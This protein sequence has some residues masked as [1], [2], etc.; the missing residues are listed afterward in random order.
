M[1]GQGVVG[2][3]ERRCGPGESLVLGETEDTCPTPPLHR[4]LQTGQTRVGGAQDAKHTAKLFDVILPWEKGDPF[5]S[6][7]RMHPTALQ[8]Q[9]TN[10]SGISAQ[11]QISPHQHSH[12]TP[13]SKH[14]Q[15]SLEASE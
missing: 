14:P 11:P 15:S 6:S 3:P 2:P 9:N 5:N 8:I 12:L 1:E 4:A 10:I 7:P 13:G